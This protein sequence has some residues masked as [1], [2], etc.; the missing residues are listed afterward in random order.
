MNK[1]TDISIIITEIVV[2]VILLLNTLLATPSVIALVI[3]I[4]SNIAM[5]LFTWIIA[6]SNIKQQRMIIISF[7]IYALFW[8]CNQ[9][10]IILGSIMGVNDLI[11]AFAFLL[12]AVIFAIYFNNI[13]SYF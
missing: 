6:I 9:F 12:N 10:I 1:R 7:M 11:S 5:V 8:I 3:S 4:V 2:G 13:R